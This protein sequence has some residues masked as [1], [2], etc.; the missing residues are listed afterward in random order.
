VKVD[1][2]L[3]SESVSRKINKITWNARWEGN[4]HE[5]KER[6]SVYW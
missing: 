3:E 2:G 4:R 5:P 1:D 6:V